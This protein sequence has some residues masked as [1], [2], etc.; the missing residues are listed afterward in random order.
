MRGVDI[1][2]GWVRVI[3]KGDKGRRV[4]LDADVAGLIQT[5]LLAGR[6]ETD[7]AARFVASKGPSRRQPLT[8]AC[9]RS[10]ATTARGPEV[11][12]GRP[13]ALR[14]SFGMVLA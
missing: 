6:P 3:G 4:P 8:P 1:G 11:L 7:S 13:H 10:S 12:A 14:Q 2:R 9:G 5:Y